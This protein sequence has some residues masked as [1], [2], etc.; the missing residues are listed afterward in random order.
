LRVLPVNTTDG[1]PLFLNVEV[2]LSPELHLTLVTKIEE[3][4]K[5][6]VFLVFGK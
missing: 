1:S 6:N 3:L 2:Q 5:V 4:Q